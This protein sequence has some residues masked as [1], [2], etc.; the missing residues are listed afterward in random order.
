MRENLETISDC[1]LFFKSYGCSH[2]HMAREYPK[3]YSEYRTIVPNNE[4]EK[5]WIFQECERNFTEVVNLI[6]S[7]V[8]ADLGLRISSMIDLVDLDGSEIWV[9]KLTEFVAQTKTKLDELAGLIIAESILGRAASISNGGLIHLAIRL[10]LSDCAK[11]L[12]EIAKYL[13][14]VV[15]ENNALSR[16]ASQVLNRNEQIREKFS[17]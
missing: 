4:L 13:A 15:R 14:E 6:E 10:K 7:G 9:A 12:H 2:F 3:Q 5:L 17:L 16:R 11:R 8:D 1:E